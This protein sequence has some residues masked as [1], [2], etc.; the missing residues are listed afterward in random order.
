M[1]RILVIS[2][3]FLVVSAGKAQHAVRLDT[4]VVQHVD[5]QGRT[6]QGTIICNKLISNDLRQIFAEL[7]HQR[8]PIER[9]RPISEYGDD[10]EHSM[11]ANNTSCYVLLLSP[12]R[13]Q[14]KALQTRPGTGHRYQSAIQS[15]CSS[16]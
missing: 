2:V 10:D 7:Y 15:L 11:Q 1:K 16:S 6:Q 14:Q 12:H 8:Y 13:W 3:L 5:F 4:L 9:I